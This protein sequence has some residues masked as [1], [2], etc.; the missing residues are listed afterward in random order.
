[1]RD[2]AD[3]RFVPQ[4][5]VWVTVVGGDGQHV[6]TARQPFLWHPWLFHYGRNWTLP[7]SGHYAI[8]VH[9]AAANF[10]RHDKIN[11]RRYAMPVDVAFEDVTVEVGQKRS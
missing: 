5:E 6:G 3:H 4:L 2:A 1:V 10:P 8:H 9:I 11:G 7:G